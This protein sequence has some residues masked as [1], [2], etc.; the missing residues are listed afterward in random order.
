MLKKL[1]ADAS[2]L[3]HSKSPC[4]QNFIPDTK[5]SILIFMVTLLAYHCK[6]LQFTNRLF[7]PF[8]ISLGY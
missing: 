1:L 8:Y 7:L 6:R 3:D 2:V 5:V 4:E